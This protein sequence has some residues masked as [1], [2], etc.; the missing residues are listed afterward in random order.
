MF[1]ALCC[2]L[3]FPQCNSGGLLQHLPVAVPSEKNFHKHSV[4]VLCKHILFCF[5]AFQQYVHCQLLHFRSEVALSNSRLE[6]YQT[7]ITKSEVLSRS[8]NMLVIVFYPKH[9]INNTGCS[10]R[11]KCHQNCTVVQSVTA[12]TCNI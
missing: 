8:S 6:K 4:A 9:L 3:S 10:P 12:S 11:E 5:P 7:F 2:Y 1:P